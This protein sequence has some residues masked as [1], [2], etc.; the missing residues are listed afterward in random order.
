MLAAG[1]PPSGNVHSKYR[2]KRPERRP[3]IEVHR[4][5]ENDVKECG[6]GGYSECPPSCLAITCD[7]TDHRNKV[8][9]IEDGYKAVSDVSAGSVECWVQHYVLHNV[10]NQDRREQR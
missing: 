6:T 1:K 7:P 8:E 4:P 5:T 9:P 10:E 2:C 3:V